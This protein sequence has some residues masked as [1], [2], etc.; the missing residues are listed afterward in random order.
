VSEGCRHCYAERISLKFGFSKLPWTGANAKANV[1]CRPDRLKKARSFKPG[2]RVFV[3]SM[4]DL[5]HEMV[6][7]GFV[8]DVLDTVRARPD[9]TFQVLTKRPKRLLAGWD[10]PDNLWVGAS[11][12]DERAW[13]R[14][15]LVKECGAKVKFL[16]VEPM[17]GP[18]PSFDPAGLDWVIVGGESGPGFRPLDP[19]WVWPLRDRCVGAGVAYFFKQ[20]SHLRTEAAV[21]MAHEDGSFWLWRQFPGDLRPPVQLPIQMSASMLASWQDSGVLSVPRRGRVAGAAQGP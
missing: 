21:G 13:P 10:W 14:A 19:K 12:E 2:T 8:Q 16:S 6:P 17:I 5:F 20:A 1:V 11:V 15:G 4:S 18:V 7:D 3:N 9:V